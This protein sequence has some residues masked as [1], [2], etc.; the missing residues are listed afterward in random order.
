MYAIA[1]DISISDLEIHYGVPYNNAYFE[2][3]SIMQ[4]Y[5]FYR[6]QGSI[7]ASKNSN[8]GNLM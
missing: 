8:L 1:F 3:A 2:I 6:I 7:Y 5:D 4:E